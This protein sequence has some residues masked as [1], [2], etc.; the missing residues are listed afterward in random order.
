[1]EDN[2]YVWYN[3][4]KPDQRGLAAPVQRLLEKIQKGV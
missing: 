2:R 1:M 3:V 4:A